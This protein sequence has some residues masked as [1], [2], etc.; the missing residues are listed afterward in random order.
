[1]LSASG[2]KGLHCGL[3]SAQGVI[4]TSSTG[5]IFL[6]NMF[7]VT[8]M[9]CEGTKFVVQLLNISSTPEQSG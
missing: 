8:R 2:R 6:K 7:F 5:M 4:S 3:I 1:L 9:F